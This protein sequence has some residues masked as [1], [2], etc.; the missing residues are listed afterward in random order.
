MRFIKK[1]LDAIYIGVRYALAAILGFAILLTFFEVIRRYLFGKS[2]V[3]SEEL[4]RYLFVYV[5]FIGG[6]AAFRD[7]GLACF[8]LVTKKISSHTARKV[9]ALVIDLG[10]IGFSLY[11]GIKGIQVVG[12]PSIARQTSAGL[13][14]PMPVVYA[15]I[16]IGFFL[17]VIFGIEN[18]IAILSMNGGEEEE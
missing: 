2:F 12:L 3:W 10:V 4:M 13:N 15:A 5:G 6:A 1:I 7:K 16:P 18:M 17:M 14:L 9:I 11:M 8:D